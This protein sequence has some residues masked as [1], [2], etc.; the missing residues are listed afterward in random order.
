MTPAQSA[1]QEL[2]VPLTS[3]RTSTL[4]GGASATNARVTAWGV[5]VAAPVPGCAP[6]PP[7]ERPITSASAGNISQN[8]MI[9]I[10]GLAS[11]A[12]LDVL[13]GPAPNMERGRSTGQVDCRLM[14][15]ALLEVT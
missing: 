15:A 13:G 1:I 6:C 14:P 9:R 12:G 10:A 11:R 5:I 7:A 2:P 8:S 3:Y 4:P